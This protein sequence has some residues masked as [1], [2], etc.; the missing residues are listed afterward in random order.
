MADHKLIDLLHRNAPKQEPKP[1]PEPDDLGLCCSR[2]ANKYVPAFHVRNGAGPIRSF[3]Y[4]HVGFKQFE[5]TRIVMEFHEP[6][7]WR[8]TVKGRNLWDLYNYLCHHRIEWI[9]KAD[10]DFEDGRKPVIT[11]IWIEKVKE[12][13]D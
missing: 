12:E 8:L 5:P 9:E 11:G 13:E 3:E 2:P 1:E 7:H 4:G 10:R 6:E